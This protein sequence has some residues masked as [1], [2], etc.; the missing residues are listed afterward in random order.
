MLD[1]WGYA[2][3][4]SFSQSFIWYISSNA[5]VASN[6]SFITKYDKKVR[7]K[8]NSIVAG[9]IFLVAK[10]SLEL[11]GH[12]HSVNELVCFSISSSWR[13]IRESEY[14]IILTSYQPSLVH[15]YSVYLNHFNTLK[16]QSFATLENF[17]LVFS[18]KKRSNKDC[19]KMLFNL[20][21]RRNFVP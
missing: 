5:S 15:Q 3:V 18:K 7:K 20:I 1:W 6:L 21:W 13:R 4:K 11:A 9:F 8:K 16:N 12:V 2:A 17:G 14:I 10:A 19:N